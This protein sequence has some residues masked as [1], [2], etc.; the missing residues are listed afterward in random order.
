M[1]DIW[2][3]T[4]SMSTSE[5][6]RV[7]DDRQHLLRVEIEDYLREQALALPQRREQLRHWDYRSLPAFLDSVRPNRE[8]WQSA[9]GRF[10]PAE[11]P[12]KVDTTPFLEDD[13]LSATWITLPFLGHYRARAVLALPKRQRPPY[14]LVVAQHGLGS[15]PERVFGFDDPSNIYK[16]YGRRL[17]EA[18]FAVLAP[19]NVTDARPRARLQRLCTL[20]GGNLAGLEIARTARLLD[21]L[22]TRDDIDAERMGMWG[23]SLGGYYTL[24]TLPLERR[25]RA[26]VITAYFNSRVHKMAIDDPRYSCYLSWDEEHI[27]V[28]GWLREFGDSDMASLICP[29]PLQ[30]QMGKGDGI[31]WWPLAAQEFEAAA[32]HYRRLGLGERVDLD[33]HEGGH[34]I[35]AE[36]G[37]RFLTRW[38]VEAPVLETFG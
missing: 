15:S 31:A 4:D 35:D 27:F 23:I 29:R 6:K 17:V 37:I 32:E 24:F 30:V 12:L 7:L 28:P 21:Y 13:S 2:S 8:R 9:V 38:L 16:A 3:A 36:A 5:V 20:L 10:G 11:G 22:E 1:R 14:P 34:E 18:G 26:G 19:L 33:L 25:L